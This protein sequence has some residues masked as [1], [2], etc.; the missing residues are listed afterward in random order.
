MQYLNYSPSSFLQMFVDPST[1]IIGNNHKFFI[2]LSN[3]FFM[4]K[5][6]TM[7]SRLAPLC[8]LALSMI[9]E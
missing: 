9:Y 8:A 2:Q 1:L 5:Y 3:I 4:I 6:S 7:N